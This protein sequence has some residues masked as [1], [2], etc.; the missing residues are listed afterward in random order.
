MNNSNKSSKNSRYKIKYTSLTEKG[1]DKEKNEDYYSQ[2][3]CGIGQVFIVCDGVGGSKAGEVASKLAVVTIEHFIRENDKSNQNIND[4]IKLSLE[5]A[6]TKILDESSRSDEYKEMATTCVLL[7]IKN[8]FAYYGHVGDSRLYLIRNE[9]LYQMTK[10]HSYPVMLFDRGDIKF[11]EIENH[12]KS[13][14][15]TQS[16]GGRS[17]RIEPDI[18]LEGLKIYKNDKFLQCS[19]GLS[20]FVKG[21]EIRDSIINFEIY[22]ASENL[23]MKRVNAKGYDDITIILIDIIEG[24]TLPKKI[25]KIPPKGSWTL[26]NS[27]S[28]TKLVN[29]EEE[30]KI[31]DE[32][33]EDEKK[34]DQDNGEPNGVW[35]KWLFYISSFVFIV[36]IL[37]IVYQN[38]LLTTNGPVREEKL[39]SKKY[40]S[41]KFLHTKLASEMNEIIN[42]GNYTNFKLDSNNF[43][44]IDHDKVTHRNWSKDSVKQRLEKSNAKFVK[45]EDSIN[46]ISTFHYKATIK[47]EISDQ[48]LLCE[49]EFNEDKGDFIFRK[50]IEKELISEYPTKKKEKTTESHKEK[51]IEEKDYEKESDK[52]DTLKDTLKDLIKIKSEEANVKI[53]ST[54]KSDEKKIEGEKKENEKKESEKKEDE[55]KENEKKE[56][57]KKESEKKEE[58]EKQ[59]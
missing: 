5:E 55:K 54:E 46:A 27:N 12:E 7:I 41:I 20:G 48:F 30:K 51:R 25:K 49:L 29:K 9:V 37:F 10:D 2:F 35:K 33:K 18:A 58:T 31:E 57:E 17:K 50:I 36:F 32:K 39:N 40:K 6:N 23:L 44:Y 8:G 22:D 43:I 42:E 28:D 15:I 47:L 53:D 45:L 26:C 34:V 4:I 1:P 19:D 56:N 13:N 3:E 38:F 24:Q 21:N 16:L 11:N 59:N 14:Q 52:K